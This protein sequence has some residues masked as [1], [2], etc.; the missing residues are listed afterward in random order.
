MTV[1]LKSLANSWPSPFVAREEIE[2]FSGG[3]LT[4]KYIA[5]L[6]SLGKGPS[7]RFRCGRKVAYPVSSLI[8]FMEARCTSLG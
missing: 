5:N 3:I 8:E 2:R 4:A 1:S 7:G 6:D